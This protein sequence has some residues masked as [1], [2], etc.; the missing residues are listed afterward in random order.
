MGNLIVSHPYLN[1]ALYLPSWWSRG[2]DYGIPRSYM[3]TR[4]SINGYA[5]INI[6]IVMGIFR[7]FLESQAM[8]PLQC[9]CHRWKRFISWFPW[10]SAWSWTCCARRARVNICGISYLCVRGDRTV[11]YD[12]YIHIN[13]GLLIFYRSLFVQQAYCHRRQRCSN[14]FLGWQLGSIYLILHSTLVW[15]LIMITN[16]TI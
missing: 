4:C 15:R 5:G 14:E 11:R 12:L 3:V 10:S 13:V 7:R 2:R 9:S 6:I 8:R 1:G 16:P